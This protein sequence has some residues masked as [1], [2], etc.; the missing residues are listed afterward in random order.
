MP[1]PKQYNAHK[2]LALPRVLMSQVCVLMVIARPSLGNLTTLN[3][4]AIR[5][6]DTQGSNI[7]VCIYLAC[8]F[9][10]DCKCHFNR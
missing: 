3:F 5:K 4:I 10:M 2:V 6:I 7:N 9:L 1:I 8:Y